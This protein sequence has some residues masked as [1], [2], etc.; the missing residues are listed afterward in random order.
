MTTTKDSILHKP[1]EP[2][3]ELTTDALVK[4]AV[5]QNQMNMN[6]FEEIVENAQGPLDINID[7][8]GGIFDTSNTH[9]LQNI[10]G[11]HGMPYQFMSSTDMKISD[12]NPSVNF[13]YGRKY[14]ERIINKMPLLLLSPGSPKFL[15]GFSKKTKTGIVKAMSDIASKGD[16]SALEEMLEGKDGKYY[17]FKF[18]YKEYYEY[19][20]G[21]CWASAI[22][23]GLG[24][25][26][27][28]GKSYTKYDWSKYVND[29][30]KGFFSGSEYVCFYID[31][32]SQISDNFSNST[33][34]SMLD[35]GLNKL[36][37]MG[38]EI[39]FL[40]NAGAGLKWDAMQS[41]N[42]DA[43]F[44]QVTEILGSY[45]NPAHIFERLKSGAVT[46][47]GGGELIFPE[48]W[49]DSSY[50]KSY[51]VTI[52]L[53]S[54]DGDTESI[55]RNILVPIWHLMGLAL[56]LQ[57]G[58]NGF[59]SPFL[60]KAF[61]K[62]LISCEMGMITNMT[63]RK[64]NQGSW[65]IDGLPTEVE[66]NLSFKDLYQIL[67]LTKRSDVKMFANNTQLLDFIANMCGIVLNKPEVMRKAQMYGTLYANKIG[68]M[69]RNIQL[70]FSQAISNTLM[71][72]LGH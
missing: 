71:K 70:G 5:A 47:A 21:M 35:S 55:Y 14:T 50:S 28:N 53:N 2:K 32:E 39:G 19:V 20:N 57:M 54:N 10:R 61:Y 25:R 31:G 29:G 6:N 30:L 59:R 13:P 52:K 72:A 67:T 9:Q 51:D 12:M 27:I 18:N 17:S 23:L 40:L 8:Y 49:K 64:G 37:D 44:E 56:P 58:H 24:D 48:I 45:K 38:K 41:E 42:Y 22:Y 33:G 26:T 4:D 36:S 62:G 34:P 63:I 43:T 68:M 7:L 1:K 69:P 15:D 46:V 16:P 65:N 3:M 60:I 11:I 66:V